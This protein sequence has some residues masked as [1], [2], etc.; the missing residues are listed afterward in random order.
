MAHM[1]NIINKHIILVNVEMEN[2]P[3]TSSVALQTQKVLSSQTPRKTRFRKVI[4]QKQRRILHFQRKPNVSDNSLNHFL[5]LCD[6]HL[7]PQLAKVV[8]FNAKNKYHEKARYSSEYKQ[9]ALN[10]YFLG[11]KVYRYLSKILQLP[12]TRTLR[13]LT[14]KWN[15]SEDICPFIFSAIKMKSSQFKEDARACILCID[16][17]SLKSN[18]FYNISNDEII[19]FHKVNGHSFYQPAKF[20]MALFAKG[21][22]VNWKQPVGYVLPQST[23][24]GKD[25][26]DILDNTIKELYAIN[27][28]VK[29]IVS[30]VGSN[31]HKFA[32][33]KGVTPETPYFY[34]NNSKIFYLF[35]TPHLIKATR[36]SFFKYSIQFNNFATNKDYLDIFYN[37]DKENQIR[38]APKL[39]DSHMNPSNFEKM[40]VK[41][42][43]QVFSQ[44]VAAALSTYMSLG[45]LPSSAVGTITFI[46]K[47]DKL[48]DILNSST[49]TSGKKYNKPFE[50]KLYQVEFL[51]EMAET[52]KNMQAFDRSG[53][54]VTGKIKN[55]R[56]W[57]ITINGI[58]MLWEDMK[59]PRIYTRRLQQDSLENFFGAIRQQCGNARNPTPVQFKR[60]FKK[61]FCMNY[62]SYV[63]G[64]NCAEDFDIILSQ[65]GTTSPNEITSLFTENVIPEERELQIDTKDYKNL[66]LPH[67]N[68]IVYVCGYLL[69]KCY[70]KHSCS[71]C[72]TLRDQQLTETTM[73][74]HFKVFQGKGEDK[75]VF[76][77]LNVPNEDFVS[78]VYKLESVFVEHFADMAIH[79]RVGFKLWQ[80][81]TDIVYNPPCTDFPTEYL[82]KLY[83]RL[84]IFYTIKFLNRELLS[85]KGKNVKL[86]IL[87]HL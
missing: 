49:A 6:E 35:D 77:S 16:E 41:L 51:K 78:Y 87:K 38:S 31:F 12:N 81:M 86:N 26:E 18:L 20:A 80:I 52:F 83:V 25:L 36:N 44:T 53:K 58:L 74:T 33:E 63:E 10:L 5:K 70:D 29:A 76:G 40:K 1:F 13:R 48:F 46:D 67:Q 11:P 8:K 28:Y 64:A 84:R 24:S 57:Q 21:I 45:A 30:D 34:I 42:A 55:F 60:A 22:S 69:K 27:L 37:K 66:D 59:K 56:C 72:L 54:N 32:T 17:I 68:A 9:F 62:C 75:G 15:I 61:L 14:Q 3:S 50:G 73:F 23:C 47:M 71:Q 65:L 85:K 2:K 79:P 7:S 39:T 4:K 19:G 82:I 43:V